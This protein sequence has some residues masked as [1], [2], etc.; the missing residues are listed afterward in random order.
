MAGG[1]RTFTKQ[2]GTPADVVALETAVIVADESLD[3]TVVGKVGRSEISEVLPMP[4]MLHP[5]MG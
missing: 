1:T 3:G 4:A 2:Y 5:A